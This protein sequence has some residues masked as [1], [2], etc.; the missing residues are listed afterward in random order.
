VEL[1]HV[2][3]PKPERG[4]VL[5]RTELSGIS[6]G[7]ELL[8]YRGEVDPDLP[9]DDSIG[10]LGGTFRFPFR[11]GYSAVGV[12][13]RSSSAEVPT[14]SRVFAFHPH[15]ELFVVDDGDTVVLGGEDPRIATLLPL[16]ETALQIALDA[17]LRLGEV[18]VV[19]GLGAVGMLAGALLARAGATVIGSDPL[20]WRRDA[21][22]GFGLNAVMPEELGEVVG[23][24]TDGRGVPLVVEASGSPEVLVASLPLLAREGIALV[25][26][27]YGTKPVPLPLGAEFH[28]KRLTIRSTQ[29]SSIP[30]AQRVR[31]NRRTRLQAARSLLGELPL[32]RIASHEFPFG[33]AADAYACLDRGDEGLVHAA[34]RYP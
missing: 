17:G 12:V 9:L 27:W 1:V 26:S 15:Q 2:D 28:R 33:R 30:A 7:T 3:V 16:V 22:K 29:V 14:G 10:A 19:T 34:L 11:Y 32:D 21:A 25:C 13:E 18:V 20:G 5:V 6:G 23:E 31:W 4:Q 24:V 8:A